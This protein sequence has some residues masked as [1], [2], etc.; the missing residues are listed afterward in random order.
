MLLA[1]FPASTRLR[2]RATGLAA[3]SQI[4]RRVGVAIRRRAAPSRPAGRAKGVHAGAGSGSGLQPTRCALVH[5]HVVVE[6]QACSQRS[7]P[8]VRRTALKPATTGRDGGRDGTAGACTTPESDG[9]WAAARSSDRPAM[10]SD[11]RKRTL[12]APRGQG[13][14]PPRALPNERRERDVRV[15]LT[16]PIRHLYHPPYPARAPPSSAAARRS[17]PAMACDAPATAI[18]PCRTTHSC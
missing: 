1:C 5:V 9:H 4:S 8:A 6:L 10:R 13:Q 15:Q 11:K 16:Y 7:R 18:A 14:A 12:N 17:P 2:R 3:L